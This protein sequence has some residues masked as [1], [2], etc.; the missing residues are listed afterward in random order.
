MQ[1]SGSLSK[2]TKGTMG[3][4]IPKSCLIHVLLLV[5]LAANKARGAAFVHW[6][7]SS[8][9]LR[10]TT[11]MLATNGEQGVMSQNQLMHTMLRV[12]NVNATVDF[13]KGRGANVH[14]YRK[15]SKAETAFVGFG[16]EQGNGYFSLEIT[17]QSENE[18]FQLGNSIQYFG[19]SM[20]M[21]MNLMRAAAGEKIAS[22]EEE[23]PNGIQV[24]PV[25][26]APGDSFARFCL[27][28]DPLK[29][30][31]FAQTTGFYEMLGMELV[32][33]DED[34]ICLRYTNN[35]DSV[36]RTGVA[37]TLVFSKSSDKLEIGNC[38]DHMAISTVNVEAAATAVQES[39]DTPDSVIFM[40]PSPM[41]GT[42]I[43][44]LTDPNGYKVYLVEQQ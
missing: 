40:E 14:S 5:A 17:K 23:D 11:C 15:T 33:A 6:H 29:E 3:R 1:H 24:R 10:P 9:L 44:G 22:T 43:M 2:L 41:F 4:I 37:T 18:V 8:M 36:N 28:V 27:K 38:F 31:A 39:L 25:A 35:N 16:P 21:G 26:S 42:K 34:L 12:P 7:Q 20:L 32:A 30:D 13:W 19:L